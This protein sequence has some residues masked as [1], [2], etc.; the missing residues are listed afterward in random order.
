M[1]I[2]VPVIS[3]NKSWAKEIVKNWVNGYL[4]NTPWEFINKSYEILSNS[5][6]EKKLSFEAVKT[7]RAFWR[8]TFEK[9]LSEIF[10]SI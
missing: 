8:Q 4:V 10:N 7:A 9:Q 3:Y 2:W 6:L 5:S 1:S